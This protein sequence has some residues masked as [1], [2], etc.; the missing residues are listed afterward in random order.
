MNL[1]ELRFGNLEDIISTKKAE[2]QYLQEELNSLLNQECDYIKKCSF[3][4]EKIGCN[5]CI[6]KDDCR[7]ESRKIFTRIDIL[8]EKIT[9][10]SWKLKSLFLELHLKQQKE[11]RGF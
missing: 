11:S 8:E 5:L 1:K 9:R 3:R 7:E 10:L 2:I 6:L 4:N